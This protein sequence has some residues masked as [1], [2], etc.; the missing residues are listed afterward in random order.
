ML[1]VRLHLITADPPV[2]DGC[3]KFIESE[4][5][6]AAES[7]PGSLGLSLLASAEPRVAVLELFWATHGAL[8]ESREQMAALRGELAR[9]AGGP[10]TDEQHRVPVFERDRPLRG[11]EAVRLTRM[12]IRPT[13]VE[14][15]IE[16]YGDTVVPRLAES[17]GF[18]GALLLDG[19]DS[20]HL[21]SET[22][23]EDPQARAAG[24]SDA[25]IIRTEILD[26][27]SYV[28]RV[29]ED[30]SLVFSSVRKP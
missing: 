4:V 21:I 17:P 23:W 18:S 27:S 22:V 9:R 12:E 13:A 8:L 25:A 11:G 6:P 19:H 26:A 7:L 3:I 2:L 14:D 16:V 5:R 28:V 30:Y 24:P 10:V 1:H 15:V 20:G 29:V